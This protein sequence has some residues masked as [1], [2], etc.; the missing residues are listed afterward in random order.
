MDPKTGPRVKLVVA[1]ERETMAG[2]RQTHTAAFKAQV[3]VVARKGDRTVNELAGPFQGVQFTAQAWTSRLE[4]A[5]VPV[6]R[7]GKGRCLDNGF[8]E[9]LWRSVKYE[10]IH[11][12]GY[13]TEPSCSGG[14]GGTS[15]TTT[16]SG[17]TSPWTS[18]RRQRATGRVEPEKEQAR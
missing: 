8:V 11:L 18:G 3:T 6:S 4:S 16:R 14:W 7:D 13:E 15:R 2:R 17:P 9:R 12:G 10:A 5:G 1:Q